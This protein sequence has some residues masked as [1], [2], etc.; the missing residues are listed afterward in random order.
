MFEFL[1]RHTRALQ[2]I[3]VLL[4]FPSF[5]FFGIQGYSRFAGS[6]DQTVAKVDGHA[7]TRAEWELAMR[8]QLERAQ[9]QMPGVDAKLFETPEMRRLSLEALVRERVLLA[10]ADKLHLVTTDDRL[11]RVFVSDPQFAPLRNP[12]G[13]VNKDAIGERGMSSE[14][15]AYRLRQDLSQRQVLLGLAGSVIAPQAATATALDAMFQQREVQVERFDPKDFRAKVEPNDADI[16]KFYSDPAHAAMFEAP[17]TESIEYV[18]L[19]LDALKKDIKVPEEE[20]RKYYTENE[21]RYTAPE[22]RRASHILIKADKDMSQ[23]ERDKAR[24]KAEALLAEIRKNPASFAELARK[25]SQDP[26]SAE[27]GGDLD[28]FGR[29]A[30][31]KPFED[32]AFALKPGE[33][34]GIVQTDFGYHIIQVTGARGGEKRPFE[35]VRG[36]IEAEIKNQLAQRRYSEAAVEFTNMVYEQP[37]SLKPVADRFK[38][39]VK[40]ASDVKRTPAPG[41]TGALASPKFLEALFTSDAIRNKRNTEAVEFGPSQMVSGR[42]LKHEAAHKLPLAEV[43]AR[44]REQVVA[45]QAAALARKAGM[46]RLSALRSA[47]ATPVEAK[48][49]TVSRAQPHEIPRELLDAVM[50]VPAD[51]LPTF[52]GVE[53]G[54]QGYALAKV[55]KV[56]GRDPVVAAQAGQA[57]A[58]Y[59]QAWADAEAQAYYAALKDRF[60]VKITPVGAAE[61][62]SAPR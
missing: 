56:E 35:A 45:T 34:S 55:L 2:A 28:F 53:L 31:V 17:E 12:D 48:S 18:V 29:G 50:K 30:M 57:R 27:K 20:L 42:V 13:S 62:A 44:V 10:A 58:Q 22:E 21:K 60:N 1:R 43:R 54:G 61:P 38:L 39:E 23:A 25:N 36:E 52:V 8:E 19:D 40:K 15:F 11:Q 16:E 9:R 26:G 33:T 32:A 7:I 37:D 4:I 59:A 3:L 41:A 6:G 5:V 24:A 47:P 51:K 46:D 49:T 14:M